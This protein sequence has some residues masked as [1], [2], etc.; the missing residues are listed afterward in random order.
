MLRTYQTEN[1]NK[2][3]RQRLERQMV[4]NSNGDNLSS[5][6]LAQDVIDSF[7]IN[8]FEEHINIRPPGLDMVLHKYSNRLREMDARMLLFFH[9]L[10]CLSHNKS[11]SVKADT[12]VPTDRRRI[13][14]IITLVGGNVGNFV[15]Q[16]YKDKYLPLPL[17]SS[18]QCIKVLCTLITEHGYI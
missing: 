17:L 5:F 7:W 16:G 3:D 1:L 6:Y 8:G 12:L 11:Y 2:T 14:A 18:V 9:A 13:R 15:D 4:D 10:Y